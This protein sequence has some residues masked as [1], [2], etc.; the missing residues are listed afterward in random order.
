MFQSPVRTTTRPG[1]V[2]SAGSSK[3]RTAGPCSCGNASTSW[4]AAC[5]CVSSPSV[6][7]TVL[8]ATSPPVYPPTPGASQPPSTKTAAAF[9][10]RPVVSVALRT[11]TGTRTGVGGAGGTST[12]AV[13]SVGSGAATSV[14]TAGAELT[15]A[16]VRAAVSWV[17]GET[18]E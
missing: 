12:V 13:G 6:K 14:V 8:A 15:A 4:T 7:K 5:R 10:A 17:W 16:G 18:K 11:V 1:A 2:M 9:A 3:N